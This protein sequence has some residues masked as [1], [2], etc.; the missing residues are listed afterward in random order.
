[1]SDRRQPFPVGTAPPRSYYRT[2]KGYQGFPKAV[3]TSWQRPI[4]RHTDAGGF[5][6]FSS[7]QLP[8]EMAR[9]RVG[10]G[11]LCKEPQAGRKHTHLPAA[12]TPIVTI[13][14][15]PLDGCGMLGR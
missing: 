13:L 3:V 6:G 15:Q 5:Q 8:R 14:L 1:M 10:V 2:G 11:V 4:P 12:I 7:R 9:R